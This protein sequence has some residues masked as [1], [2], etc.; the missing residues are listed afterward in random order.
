MSRIEASLNSG[1]LRTLCARDT[2]KDMRLEVCKQP[3]FP[4]K[5]IPFMLYYPKISNWHLRWQMRQSGMK[6]QIKKGRNYLEVDNHLCNTRLRASIWK[7]DHGR[8]RAE[9]QKPEQ[10]NVWGSRKSRRAEQ[11]SL[12]NLGKWRSEKSKVRERTGRMLEPNRVKESQRAIV[13]GL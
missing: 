6:W 12:V 4:L 7:W 3:T 11:G 10:R 9:K 1:R 5:I 8:C 13:T 2:W